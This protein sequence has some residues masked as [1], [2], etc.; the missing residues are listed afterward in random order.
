V[1]ITG[2]SYETSTWVPRHPE[3]FSRAEVIRQ[4]G[5]FRAA[6]PATITRW[7]PQF[8]T[9]VVSDVE[10]ASRQLTE[11]D[12]HARI[13]LGNDNPALGPMSAILLRTES[14]SSSQIERLTTSAKQLALAELGEGGRSNAHM[15]VGNVRAMEAALRLAHDLSEESILQMHHALM[16]HQHDVGPDEAGIYRKEFVW[17]G[18]GDAGPRTADFVPPH[19]DRVSPAM[20]D[21]MGFLGR[22]DL[23]ILVQ[24]AV[25]HA[26]FETIHPFVDGNGRTGR[27]LV[28]SVLK[29]KGLVSG[30]AVPI[31]AGLLTDIDRYFVALGSFRA[32]DAGPIIAEFARAT[33]LAAVSGRRLLDELSDVLHDSRAK[34]TG[35]RSDAAVWRI[36]PALVA[37]PV[38]KAKHLTETLGL[39]EMAASR[40]LNLL[41]E[42]G[43]LREVTGQRR[44][45]IF[46]HGGVLRVLDDYARGIRRVAG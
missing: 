28:Q 18:E 44:N 5:E 21:L 35:I 37:Q 4:T 15:V 9:E 27:A 45:R 13:V 46:E 31:S 19:P 1:P 17:L 12:R 8:S 2:V 7:S 16:I 20:A 42:R 14:A 24:A 22:G 36:L 41:T 38:I 3:A 32:G 23:P 39:G 29:N 25:G 30:M 34:L 43:V 33:R 26:Q 11:F 6:I 40:A 10:D